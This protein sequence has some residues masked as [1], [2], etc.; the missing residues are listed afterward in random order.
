MFTVTLKFKQ[1][2]HYKRIYWKCLSNGLTTEL[3]FA[4]ATTGPISK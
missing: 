4:R 3:G 1:E 2:L